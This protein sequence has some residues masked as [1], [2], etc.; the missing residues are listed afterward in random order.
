MVLPLPLFL[1]LTM[2]ISPL[3]RVPKELIAR[4][5]RNCPSCTL[6]RSS[7][8]EFSAASNRAS[9]TTTEANPASSPYLN[10]P[11]ST[12]GSPTQRH[13]MS[14]PSNVTGSALAQLQ[15]QMSPLP[16]VTTP[17]DQGS[18]TQYGFPPNLSLDPRMYGSQSGPNELGN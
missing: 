3:H 17:G 16:L 8:L 2:L 13:A 18:Y 1:L 15:A 9:Q 14:T 12:S 4:F 11:S 7:P 5:V 6:R 10:S